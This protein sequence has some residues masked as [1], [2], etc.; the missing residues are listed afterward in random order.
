MRP[1]PAALSGCARRRLEPAS[2]RREAAAK[3]DALRLGVP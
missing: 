1:N 3:C 2:A